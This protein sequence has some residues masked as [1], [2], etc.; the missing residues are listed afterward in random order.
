MSFILSNF[1]NNGSQVLLVDDHSLFRAGLSLIISTHPLV[2]KVHAAEGVMAALRL[3]IN[4]IKLVLLDIFMPG[5]KGLE[6]IV[7]LRS[8]FPDAVIAMVSGS[9][10]YQDVNKAK[11]HGVSGFLFKT[12]TPTEFLRAVSALLRGNEWFPH[13]RNLEFGKPNND[14]M[15]ALSARQMLVLGHLF[16]GLSNRAIAMRMNVSENTVR[17][18]VRGVLQCLGANSRAEAVVAARRLGIVG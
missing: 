4:S 2:S 6:G 15:P 17:S 8:K 1:N 16:E 13:S 18:H 12:D 7:V 11:E 14:G 3:E 5:I 9:G 10:D